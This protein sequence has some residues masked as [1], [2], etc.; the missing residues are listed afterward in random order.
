MAALLLKDSPG[1]VVKAAVLR[2]NLR[3]IRKL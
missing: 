2:Y 3:A 1:L